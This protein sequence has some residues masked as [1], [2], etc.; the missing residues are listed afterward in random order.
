MSELVSLPF[1]LPQAHR[2]L[3]VSFHNLLACAS[4]YPPLLP[5]QG[6]FILFYFFKHLNKVLYVLNPTV[7]VSSMAQKNKTGKIFHIW[8]LNKKKIPIQKHGL[9]MKQVIKANDKVPLKHFGGL[10]ISNI[11]VTFWLYDMKSYREWH[12]FAKTMQSF[13][14]NK[15]CSIIKTKY[16]TKLIYPDITNQ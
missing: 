13:M 16:T 11:L 6:V 12:W 2:P 1:T 14:Q 7:Q 15:L 3:T 10:F 5:F 4:L 8:I 9:N